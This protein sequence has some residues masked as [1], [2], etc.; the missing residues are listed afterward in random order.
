MTEVNFN[1]LR[2]DAVKSFNKIAIFLNE[3]AEYGDFVHGF[4]CEEIKEIMD[5]L[6]SDLLSMCCCSIK[7]DDSFADISEK[8]EF[9]EFNPSDEDE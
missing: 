3:Q 8:V 7:G 5:D 6:R 4:H 2:S 1:A 9:V